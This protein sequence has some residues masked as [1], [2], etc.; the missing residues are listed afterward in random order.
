MLL[1]LRVCGAQCGVSELHPQNRINSSVVFTFYSANFAVQRKNKK[2]YCPNKMTAIWRGLTG[3]R[4]FLRSSLGS[5]NFCTYVEQPKS[6]SSKNILK[7]SLI[8]AVFGVGIGATYAFKR[9]NTARQRLALEG[10]ELEHKLLKYKPDV[11]I[12]RRV[13]FF[14]FLFQQYLHY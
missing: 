10:T 4:V 5:R 11:K 14:F 8:G 9:I 7:Y 6:K 1:L 3:G 13:S 12:S 2:S